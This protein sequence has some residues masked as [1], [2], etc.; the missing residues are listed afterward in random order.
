MTQNDPKIETRGGSGREF[1]FSRNEPPAGAPAAVRA[2]EPILGG[3]PAKAPPFSADEQA[4]TAFLARAMPRL[5]G[6]GGFGTLA[7]R[8]DPLE[9]ADDGQPDD[10]MDALRRIL[11]EVLDRLC[12]DQNGLW[13]EIGGDALACFLPGRNTPQCREAARSIQ[14]AL[15]E[16]RPETVTVGIAMFPCIN[17]HRRQMLANARKA[18]EHAAFFGPGSRVVFDAVSLNI[19]GDRF[20]QEGD[21]DGAVEEFK[22]ALL[23]DPTE[24]NV[25]NS[26]GVCYGLLGRLDEALAAF[27]AAVFLDP[28]EALAR[29]NS[30]L[31]HM[32]QAR[33]DE[34]LACF[35]AAARISPDLFEVAFQTGKLY[36]IKGEPAKALAF[37]E[38]A[39]GLQPAAGPAQACLGQ[40]YEAL[41][42]PQE[43]I[44]AYKRAVKQNPGDAASLSAIGHLF[45]LQGENP[46]IATLFCRQSVALEP[47]SGLYHYRLGR[48]LLKQDQVAAALEAFEAARERGHDAREEIDSLQRRLTARAS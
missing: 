22:R 43:A 24:V 14:Q 17:Y 6:A 27:E 31:V 8:I 5:T 12:R 3:V 23:L 48:L 38:K 30:G 45:D 32:L 34:A 35:H 37:L 1:L 9:A 7:I 11:G 16:R 29:Y 28:D 18:V 42:R 47:T 21:F 33:S 2:A 13:A 25:H 36:L 15:S 41:G 10:R 19:S 26:L 39:A 44:A 4:E 40:C 46:E 20:Y